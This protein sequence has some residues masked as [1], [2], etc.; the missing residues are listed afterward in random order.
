MTDRRPTVKNEDTNGII[1]G[2]VIY[3]VYKK[4]EKESLKTRQWLGN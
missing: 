1:K 2:K 4:N 3:Q